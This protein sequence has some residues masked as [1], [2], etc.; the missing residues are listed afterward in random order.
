MRRRWLRK[1]AKWL[2]TV[3]ALTALGVSVL[4][5]FRRA[6]YVWVS[7]DSKTLRLVQIEGGQ[8]FLAQWNGYDMIG[9]PMHEGWSIGRARTWSWGITGASNG[10]P[11]RG[12]FLW[13]RPNA[14]VGVAWYVGASLLYP[15]ILTTVPAA[16]LWYAD[17]RRS[18]PYA[19]A[20][21]G[22][23][24]TGLATESKCPECGAAAAK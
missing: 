3:A 22:Y 10:P 16:L 1:W 15:A 8:L 13:D 23:D 12:G 21:C 18:G 14:I 11:W 20:T 7:K 4:S 2:C 9:F 17:R 6:L 5:G 24:R 19:C